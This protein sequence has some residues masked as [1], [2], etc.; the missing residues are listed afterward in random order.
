MLHNFFALQMSHGDLKI[1]RRNIVLFFFYQVTC[2][3]PPSQSWDQ[4][5]FCVPQFFNDI[6][7]PV[8]NL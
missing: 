7:E 1:F 6:L 5:R 3:P 4:Y 8:P 2:F